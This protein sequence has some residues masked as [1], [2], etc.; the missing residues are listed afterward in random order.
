MN[1]AD[2]GFLPSRTS[3]K[4]TKKKTLKSPKKKKK[5]EEKRIS[6]SYLLLPLCLL[7]PNGLLQ[8]LRNN[9][10]ESSRYPFLVFAMANQS[11]VKSEIVTA[12]RPHA[13]G[14]VTD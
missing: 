10:S 7:L 8:L 5:K 2:K 6:T 12:Q 1:S 3:K 4:K 9:R 14:C 13:R 11:H